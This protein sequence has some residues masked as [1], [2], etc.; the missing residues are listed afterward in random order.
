MAFRR[1]QARLDRIENNVHGSINEVR[2]DAVEILAGVK[3]IVEDLKDDMLDDEELGRKLYRV[4]KGFAAAAEE[5]EDP[6]KIVSVVKRI[7]SFFRPGGS[8]DE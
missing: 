7:M 3:D 8:T 4:A 6:G 1:L 5:D 2:S